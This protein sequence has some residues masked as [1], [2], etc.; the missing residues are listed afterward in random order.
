M[1]TIYRI[2]TRLLCF[3]ELRTALPSSTTK[4]KILAFVQEDDIPTVRDLS[5]IGD[6]RVLGYND[7][8]A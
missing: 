6:F 7:N 5:V 3:V 4:Y 8:D 1:N 2:N